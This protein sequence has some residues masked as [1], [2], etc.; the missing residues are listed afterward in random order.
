[1]V[2]DYKRW[3]SS[4]FYDYLKTIQHPTIALHP[5]QRTAIT[6]HS[7]S[8][9]MFQFRVSLFRGAK[10][11]DVCSSNGLTARGSSHYIMSGLFHGTSQQV[12][13]PHRGSRLH[14]HKSTTRRSSWLTLTRRAEHQIPPEVQ[15]VSRQKSII[16][17]KKI[18][19][20]SM[21]FCVWYLH[22]YR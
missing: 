11:C 4:S 17:H 10:M 3:V 8:S 21:R 16:S 15:Q 13:Q 18:S 12:L 6:A 9:E 14:P 5:T 1:M 7:V 20:V 19:G 22:L 2:E